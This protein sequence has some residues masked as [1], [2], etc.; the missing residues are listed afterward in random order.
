ML[1]D[2]EHRWFDETRNME[3]LVT[4]DEPL[5]VLGCYEQLSFPVITLKY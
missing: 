1:T 2:D 3:A 4:S 5:K